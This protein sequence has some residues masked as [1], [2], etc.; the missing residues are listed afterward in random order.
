MAKR[1]FGA[2][3]GIVAEFAGAA[4]G[5]VTDWRHGVV[6]DGG[7]HFD[8]RRFD[9]GVAARIR[10]EFGVEFQAVAEAVDVQAGIG[11]DE[12][13]G[14]ADLETIL[15]QQPLIDFQLAFVA[16][17]PFAIDID[18]FGLAGGFVVDHDELTRRIDPDVI[19]CP[20]D[21]E[22]SGFVQCRDAGEIVPPGI[23]V[24]V[25][26]R[27]RFDLVVEHDGV[28]RA[29]GAMEVELFFEKFVY[30]LVDIEWRTARP[31]N[32]QPRIQPE[33]AWTLGEQLNLGP[34]NL[35][36]CRLPR[37]VWLVALSGVIHGPY[38]NKLS[39]DGPTV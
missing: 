20:E 27:D 4:H 37:V 30:G 14:V 17:L 5:G 8:K 29:G 19:N 13:A 39:I 3:F 34:R 33:T 16:D 25:L 11:V 6:F 31:G 2:S 38:C 1:Q 21:M 26:E 32:L 9:P 12:I 28:R 23:E 18:F 24:F 15:A 10:D 35:K 22:V 7:F 36:R